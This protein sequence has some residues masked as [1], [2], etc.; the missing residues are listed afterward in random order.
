[1]DWQ[2]GPGLYGECGSS[3]VGSQ[4]SQGTKLQYLDYASL[5]LA[6]WAPWKSPYGKREQENYRSGD[7]MNE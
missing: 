2:V 1:M 6:N 3:F 4:E 5:H 7:L